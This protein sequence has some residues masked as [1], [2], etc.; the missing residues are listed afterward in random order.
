MVAENVYGAVPA[1]AESVKGP[2]AT[3]TVPGG[4][5][6]GPVIC[7]YVTDIGRITLVLFIAE[8]VTVNCGL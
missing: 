4:N 1:D 7:V 3:P 6:D 2:Y 5:D 8:S